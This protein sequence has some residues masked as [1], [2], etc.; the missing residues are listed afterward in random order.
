MKM[1]ALVASVAALALAACG[2]GDPVDV[3]GGNGGDSPEGARGG[4]LV[5][6]ISGQPDQ[7]DPQSTSA[8]A[9]FQVLENVFDTLVEPDQQLQFQPALATEWDT[10][11]DG[12]T[13]TFTLR[14]GVTWHN[15]RE[16]VADDVVYSYNRIIDDE[17]ANAYRFE[18]VESV[19][20]P[21]DRTVQIKVSRPTPNLLA[22]IGAFKGTA[23]VARENV[24]DGSI[25]Q[26]PIGTGPFSFESY[27]PGDRLTLVRNDDYW[28]DE[29]KLDG[30]EFRFISEPTVALTNLQ[31]G[32]V[33]W[34]DNLPPQQVDSLQ[35]SEDITVEAVASN[36]YWYLA[37]NVKREPFDDPRVRQAM[38][39]G[40]DREAI[41]EAATFGL[42]TPNQTAI[43]EGSVF[44]VDYAPYERDV[45]RAR[46]LL[47]EA[48][49][50]DLT[51]DLMVTNEYP[52]TVTAAQVIQSQL[53]E[54]GITVEIRTLD[55][56]A[57]LDQ[58]G[59]GNFDMFM[60]GWLGNIDPDDF[61]YAQHRTGANFNFHGYSNP[62]VDQ[63]LDSARAETDEDT[64]RGLY[65]QA[66]RLIV[67]DASYIYL[68]NPQVVQGWTPD[69]EG[70][71]VRAD[72]AIRFRDVSLAS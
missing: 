34:T 8:Y 58:Q 33:H 17:L 61:Y 38:A 72:R 35:D 56:A 50:T 7:L 63:L 55:F 25:G 52:E 37:P 13:W 23:I 62:E 22:N 6:A 30:V 71:E 43:P 40:I 32:Q 20:A 66:V 10:S 1:R 54:V 14:E 31:G 16:F 36:D 28:G 12:L 47:Q 65:D 18:S 19:T 46:S 27:A 41:T 45:D 2:G 60:L 64:R 3:G 11:E 70:Y 24:E 67:D 39:Y 69:V 5:A 9:S 29:V 57:W 48:G 68:Y 42:A 15:G 26:N 53:E 49:V 59:A 51:V 44:Y 4:T 21:D